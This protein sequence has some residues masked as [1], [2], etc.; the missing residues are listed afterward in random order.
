MVLALAVGLSASAADVWYETDF[1]VNSK[2]VWRGMVLYNVPAFQP[3]V[4]VGVGGLYFNIWASQGLMEDVDY[5]Y[6][7]GTFHEFD[8][9]LA[10]ALESDTLELEA[11]GMVYTNPAYE[12]ADQTNELFVTAAFVGVPLSPAVGF[13]KDGDQTNGTYFTIGASHELELASGAALGFDLT[14]GFGDASYGAAN[15]PDWDTGAYDP[16]TDASGMT[17]FALATTLSKA[18]IDDEEGEGIVFGWAVNLTLTQVLGPY[19][20]NAKPAGNAIL[21]VSLNASF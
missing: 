15:F 10:Y 18:I 1:A 21:G 5:E 9:M 11:G 7:A 12:E 6:E 13:Y 4:S 3:S 20:D 8:Y 17:D 19:A 16:D 2:F 14:L